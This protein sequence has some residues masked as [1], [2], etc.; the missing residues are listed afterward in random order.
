MS[1]MELP[2]CQVRYDVLGTEYINVHIQ[3]FWDNGG[4]RGFRYRNRSEIAGHLRYTSVQGL[5]LP[6]ICQIE[7]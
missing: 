3:S 5:F 1:Q 7:Q 6:N 2:R 4:P